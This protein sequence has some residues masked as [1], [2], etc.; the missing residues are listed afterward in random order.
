MRNLFW[1]M[2]VSLDGY[3]EGPNHELDWH[4]VDED[5]SNYALDML[6]SIDAILLGRRTYELFAE[7]WPTANEPEARLMNE[8]PKIVFSRT[9]DKVEWSN[10]RLVKNHVADEVTRLKE[11]TGKGL[12]LLGSADLAATLMRAGLIDEYRLHINPVVLGAG[13]PLFRPGSPTTHLRLAYTKTLKS[14]V[15]VLNYQPATPAPATGTHPAHPH[16][17]T[18]AS[19]GSRT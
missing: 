7:F 18:H 1:Q 5:F 12:A 19:H 11:L 13:T 8:L 14:G 2:M 10:S 16:G 15:V 4:V 17:H 6:S 3:M 9:L